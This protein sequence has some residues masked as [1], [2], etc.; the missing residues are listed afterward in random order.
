TQIALEHECSLEHQ[1]C[2]CDN[3]PHTGPHRSDRKLKP[4]DW[5]TLPPGMT[6]DICLLRSVGHT[7]R[8][9]SGLDTLPG[10]ESYLSKTQYQ[11]LERCIWDGSSLLETDVGSAPQALLQ[12]ITAALPDRSYD[13]SHDGPAFSLMEINP[14]HRGICPTTQSRAGLVEACSRK[15]LTVET[16]LRKISAA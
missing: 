1:S 12:P 11:E 5:A 3:G 14:D 16:P 2:L 4:A 13:L 9:Q 15:A 10:K 7:C 6:P 8:R